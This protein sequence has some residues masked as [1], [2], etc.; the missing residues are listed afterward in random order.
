LKCAIS[1]IRSEVVLAEGIDPNTAPAETGL[2]ALN[3]HDREKEPEETNKKSDVNQKRRSSFQTS[4]D[5]LGLASQ[6]IEIE[7]IPW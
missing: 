7:V 6:Q 3:S 4:K 2:E 5:D 1:V